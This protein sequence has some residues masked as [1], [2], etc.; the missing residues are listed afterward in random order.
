MVRALFPGF[1]YQLGNLLSSYNVVVQSNIAE[2]R[3]D[4]YAYALALFGG[5]VAV[6]LA[7]WA[8]LGP[9]KSTGELARA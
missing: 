1:V 2:G 6:L 8:Q 9:E 3:G 5:S 7:I 4:D